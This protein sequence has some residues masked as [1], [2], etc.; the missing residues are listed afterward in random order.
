MF[1]F[2]PGENRASLNFKEEVLAAFDFLAKEYQFVIKNIEVTFV[3]YESESV[4]VNIYH[5]RGSYELGVEIGRFVDTFNKRECPYSLIEIIR[6]TSTKE[7]PSFQV[8]TLEAVKEFV[9]KLAEL[10]S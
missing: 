4:F 8:S 10:L 2:E 7:I 9:P 3:R 1:K 6:L 5:G